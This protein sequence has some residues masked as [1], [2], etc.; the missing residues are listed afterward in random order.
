[1]TEW[2]NLSMALFWAQ[3][4]MAPITI[5]TALIA[6]ATLRENR[7]LKLQVDA[8]KAFGEGPSGKLARFNPYTGKEAFWTIGG[9]ET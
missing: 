2:I 8:L 1:M 4:M 6:V 7:I 9:A 5:A 3:A